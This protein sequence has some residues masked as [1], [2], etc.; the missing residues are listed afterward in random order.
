MKKFQTLAVA[1]AAALA[2]SAP[3]S[4]EYLYGF[5]SV[6]VNY[7]DWTDKTIDRNTIDGNK[8]KTDFLFLEAEG[9]AGFTWGDVYGFIDLE[10]PFAGSDKS[11]SGDATRVAI[12]GTMGIN[13]GIENVQFY[14]QNYSIMDSSGFYENNQVYGV[15]YNI[16]TESGFWMKPFIGVHYAA[17]NFGFA[18]WNG[19]MAGYVLGY[20]FKIGS[21]KFSVSQWHETEFARDDAYGENGVHESNTGH[22]GAVAL[23]W[24]LPNNVTTGLQYR[25]ADAK[26]GNAAYQDGLIYTVKYNF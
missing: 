10:N 26:L 11:N 21:Q 14:A 16:F 1:G 25:Y 6:S 9:G 8:T 18:D 3:A 7:L 24:H 12:K 23:W 22:N 5:G 13:T 2:L 15:R 17:N 19:G 20:D 4:A